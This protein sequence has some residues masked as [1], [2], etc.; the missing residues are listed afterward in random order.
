MRRLGFEVEVH[1]MGNVVGSLETGPGPCVLLDAHMDTVGVAD[2]GAWTHDPWGE[3]VGGRVYGRGAMDIKGP[4]AA[5][6]FGIT[7][8]RGPLLRGKAVV[9]ATIGAG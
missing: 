5:A 3:R 4:L 7:A 9:S 8:L 1:A 6:V 2:P